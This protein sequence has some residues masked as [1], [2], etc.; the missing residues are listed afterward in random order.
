M[1]TRKKKQTTYLD[2]EKSYARGQGLK[3][4][5]GE[6]N[7][8]I[9]V[10]RNGGRISYTLTTCGNENAPQLGRRKRL[11]YRNNLEH[12]H[13]QGTRNGLL[14]QIMRGGHRKPPGDSN[15]DGAVGNSKRLETRKIL[16]KEFLLQ[17]DIFQNK[18][19]REGNV[20]GCY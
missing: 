9:Y 7:D 11:R 6:E 10:G 18:N 12:K 13:T 3:E 20:S 17:T 8:R 16:E 1:A 2:T 19:V 15:R 14:P 5:N 4:H